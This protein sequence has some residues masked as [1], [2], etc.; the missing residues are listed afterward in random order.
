MSPILRVDPNS[1]ESLDKNKTTEQAVQEEAARVQ[2]LADY[3]ERV[4]EKKPRK[5]KSIE[6][7]VIVDAKPE[8][9]IVIKAAAPIP[10]KVN[11]FLAPNGEINAEELIEP[12]NV[13]LA[14]IEHSLKLMTKGYKL[15]N[16]GKMFSTTMDIP[17]EF[18]YKPGVTR[19]SSSGE[20][21]F[22]LNKPS[23]VSLKFDKL[24]KDIYVDRVALKPLD[25]RELLKYPE[26]A[27]K[28]LKTLVIDG[29]WRNLWETKK[30]DSK[31]KYFG[32]TVA[33]LKRPGMGERYVMVSSGDI[34]F[35]EI[36][37]YS[38]ITELPKET[39]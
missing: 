29:M 26:E 16:D 5:K 37:L 1:G 6:P 21:A 8:T 39:K 18:E 28:T 10:V 19:I 38:D 31:N 13:I 33:S 23:V 2:A 35:L 22:N 20:D 32:T 14:D 12:L 36:R 7:E 3:K 17:K 34:D 24:N 11:P 9:G 25:I 27:K 15:E 4:K 30:L